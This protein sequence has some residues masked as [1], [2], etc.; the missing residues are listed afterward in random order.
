MS[1]AGTSSL[2]PEGLRL[3]FLGTPPDNHSRRK[4]KGQELFFE[5]FAGREILKP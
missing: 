2:T 3:I 4:N 1:A 5:K